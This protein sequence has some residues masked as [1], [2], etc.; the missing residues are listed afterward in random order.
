MTP[1]EKQAK[2]EKLR[3]KYYYLWSEMVEIERELKELERETRSSSAET[4]EG[5][6]HE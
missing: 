3:F 2:V 4:K 5:V 6:G 1:K